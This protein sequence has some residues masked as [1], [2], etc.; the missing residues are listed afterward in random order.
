MNSPRTVADLLGVNIPVEP[1]GAVGMG[2]DISSILTSADM[3]GP[4]VNTLPSPLIG[5]TIMETQMFFGIWV[6][7]AN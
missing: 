3:H 4:A 5:R 1:E 7:E 6:F 2:I